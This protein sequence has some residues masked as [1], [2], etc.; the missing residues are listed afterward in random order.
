VGLI[1][2]DKYILMKAFFFVSLIWLGAIPAFAAQS[3][4]PPP[5]GTAAQAT[6]SDAPAAAPAPSA[7]EHH[8]GRQ[9]W[10]QK[11]RRWIQPLRD[12]LIYPRGWFFICL[13]LGLALMAG[14]F[15]TAN[16]TILSTVLAV[17]AITSG[18]LALFFLARW[19]GYH[20]RY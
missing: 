11:L 4:T 12:R 2:A 1:L 17:T 6:F 20:W 19:I 7:R 3:S 5:Q 13:G 14:A 18:I 15:L 16:L 10:G 8:R 9:R